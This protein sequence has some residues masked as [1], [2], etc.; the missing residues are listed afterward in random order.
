MIL[1]ELTAIMCLIHF[2]HIFDIRVEL[3]TMLL[4]KIAKMC[5]KSLNL[6]T[7]LS[8]FK[9]LAKL[10]NLPLLKTLYHPLMHYRLPNGILGWGAASNSHLAKLKIIHK[11]F[12]KMILNKKKTYPTDDINVLNWNNK[13]IIAINAFSIVNFNPDNI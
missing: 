1:Q 2:F 11:L 9:N 7:L 8:R 4:I 13:I 10:L 3:L 5:R 12:L 6:T